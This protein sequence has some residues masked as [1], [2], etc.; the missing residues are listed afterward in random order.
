MSTSS[1]KRIAAAATVLAF[2]GSVS[3]CATP[4]E[5]A[6]APDQSVGASP[7]TIRGS[8]SVENRGDH[9]VRLTMGLEGRGPGAPDPRRI[10]DQL[11]QYRIP[12]KSTSVLFEGPVLSGAGNAYVS[13]TILTD[14]CE[15]LTDSVSFD[16]T[17]HLLVTVDD[18][19]RATAANTATP[20]TTWPR[21]RFEP[22]CAL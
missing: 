4:R 16:V 14:R 6:Q 21:A 13:F 20:P 9:W 7:S 19:G 2:V 11:P 10:I 22:Q 15:W 5:P 3:A 18:D 8:V 1:M 12:P 17:G